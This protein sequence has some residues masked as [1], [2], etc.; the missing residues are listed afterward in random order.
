MDFYAGDITKLS[1]TELKALSEELLDAGAL[2]ED[3][4][5]CDDSDWL[6]QARDRY[7]ALNREIEHRW[8]FANPEAAEK[9]RRARQ[10]TSDL[11]AIAAQ[12][13]C[14]SERFTRMFEQSNEIA[15]LIKG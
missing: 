14:N 7:F 11:W 10:V 9:R 8:E 5:L 3:A 6:K 15:K 2:S 4:Y 1:D 13:Y 12:K